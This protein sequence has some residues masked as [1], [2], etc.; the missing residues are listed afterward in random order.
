MEKVALSSDKYFNV[1]NLS[2]REL[3]LNELDVL[4]KGL[5]FC[6]VPYEL[7]KLKLKLD[8]DAYFRR[9]RLSEFFEKTSDITTEHP[10]RNK[11]RQP[12]SWVPSVN[13]D[14]FLESY[15]TVAKEEILHSNDLIA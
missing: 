1:I 5:S 13:R 15:I 4:S 3:T 12:P 7:D 8:L 9:L 11:F 14:K 6:P 10:S 2:Q